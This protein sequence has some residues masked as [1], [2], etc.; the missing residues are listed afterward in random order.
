MD[1]EAEG[2][3]R[4]RRMI[5]RARLRVGPRAEVSWNGVSEI[6]KEME[7]RE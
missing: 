3:E 7:L 4:K 6:E 5:V 1:E 2:G